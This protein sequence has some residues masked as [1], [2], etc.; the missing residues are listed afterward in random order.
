VSP[1]KTGAPANTGGEMSHRRVAML[2]M[3]GGWLGRE[4]V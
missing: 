3:I 1:G 2:R 4:I